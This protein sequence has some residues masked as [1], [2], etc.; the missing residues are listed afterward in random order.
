[1]QPVKKNISSLNHNRLVVVS[2]NVHGF[3]QG[4]T[5]IHELISNLVPDVIFVQEHWLTPDNLF[6]LDTISEEYFSYGSSAMHASVCAGP[7]YGR[8]YGGTAMLINKK[9]SSCVS[10]ITCSDRFTAVSIANWLLINAYM[11]SS[12]T[13]QRSLIYNDLLQEIQ[14]IIHSNSHLHCLI[15]G[16]FN[17]DLNVDN[18]F[19][20]A[21]RRFIED[22]SLFRC[23]KL[24]PVSAPFTYV[25]NHLH[26]MS[27]IDYF[28]TSTPVSTVAFNTIDL[29]INLSDHIPI[30]AVCLCDKTVS[31]AAS[32]DGG[33]CALFLRWDHAPVNL[34]YERT[35]EL[36][37]PVLDEL[38]SLFDNMPLLPRS[39]IIENVDRL[40]DTLI[41][42]LRSSSNIF[43]PKRKK[44][45]YK[46]WW[47]QELDSLKD[48]AIASCRI[49]KEAGKPRHG[50]VYNK[51]I[52]DKLLYKQ[53]IKEEQA[54]ETCSF[55]NE[56][57]DALLCKT[58]TEFWKC[59]NSKFESKTNSVT[60]IDGTSDHE[61]IAANF[62]N[63]FA[64]TCSPFSASRNEEFE[65][66]FNRLLPCYNG[67]SLNESQLF[68]VELINDCLYNM[69]NG[70]APGLDE[71]SCEHLKFSHPIV[72]VILCKLFNIFLLQG[73]IPANFGLSYTVPIPKCDVRTRALTAD[74]FRG[75]SI[76]PV[77]SKLFELVIIDRFSR[78][79]ET[80]EHQFG[81]KKHLS[82]R[83]AIYCV[84]NIVDYYVSNGTT[85][86]MCLIDLSKAFDKMNHYALLIKL[87]ERKMPLQLITIFALWFRCS[88]T[89][90][91]WGNCLS[92]FF[93]LTA[94]VRQGG[95][96]SPS[97]FS[98]YIDSL[99]DKVIA[100][101]LGCH[102]SC[103]SVSILLY[104]DDIVLLS[105]TV[106]GLQELFQVCESELNALDMKINAQKT[107]CV[108]FGPAFGATCGNLITS[109]NS[110]IRWV[111]S[112]RYLGIYFVSGRVLRCS[113]D[114][115]KCKFFRAFNSILS[116][117]GRFASEEVTLSLLRAKCIPRLLYAVEACPLL[118]R[119]KHSFEFT[120]TRTLMKLF[121]TVSSTVVL[122]CQ[123]FFMFLPV[124]YDI[125][126]R[127][128][129]F[130][131]LFGASENCICRCFSLTAERCKNDI[132][133]KYDRSV[134][135]VSLLKRYIETAFYG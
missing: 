26:A 33:N 45:F 18:A 31:P 21:V 87:M 86:N 29:D 66:T 103:I 15:G 63:H 42:S 106:T 93:P 80:S 126:L 118:S 108:R 39:V 13:D 91:K 17:T 71:I 32:L 104:A 20:D 12:G 76:S 47:N 122:A 128:A 130:L 6:K 109:N 70:K 132:Y 65:S 74:D 133:L 2:Y 131:Q 7:L 88:K 77:V 64:H 56:L 116:K 9:L 134:T 97:L 35:R 84:R 90:V 95:V 43:I 3:N 44:N 37:Q 34:Y 117:I 111:N 115:A 57:H 79:F 112:C 94:G 102:V 14:S 83:H 19:S 10:A 24:F 92:F 53:K 107:I 5:G 113:Y 28:I 73:Y 124:T 114:E 135:S 54:R 101:K 41:N 121:G 62:A 75:I 81:F 46:F 4:L 96:L 100:C 61:K 23:D 60:S 72:V 129:K 27:I 78:F 11:P 69:S 22:N 110:L 98:I 82:C 49:W 67:S 25:N 1:M 120:V 51:Y 50:P 127:T 105:P 8:P 123:R 68:T 55:T 36:L 30:M 40:Y 125:D 38:N 59:W 85:V 16:D 89:C 119:D 58:G 48:S 52:Q 99:V